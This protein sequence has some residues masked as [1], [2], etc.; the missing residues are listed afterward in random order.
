MRIAVL[1]SSRADYGIYQP[2]LMKMNT[3]A[4]F[5]LEIIAFGMHLQQ[6]QGNTIEFIRK[7][8]YSKIHMVG[9]MPE[10]D[11]VFDIACGY[12]VLVSEFAQ[13]WEGNTFDLV[14]ALGDRWEMSAAVQ[15]CIPFEIK[16]AHFHGGETTL[17]A[18][19]NIYRHQISLAAH[20][21][22]TSE[23]S[24]SERVRLLVNRDVGIHTV[25][26]ISLEHVHQLILPEWSEVKENFNIPF[27]RFVLVTLH[28]ETVKSSGNAEYVRVAFEVLK[29]L[30]NKLNILITMANSDA[31]GSLYNNEFKKL[32]ERYP[33]R[34]RLVPALGRKNYFRAMK[35]CAFLLGNTS[36]GIVE[37]ASF[38]KWV[39]NV[40]N[41]QKGRLRNKNVLDVPFETH[42]ILAKASEVMKRAEYDGGNRYVKRGTIDAII[43][44]ITKDARL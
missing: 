43:G 39:I 6:N 8:G 25:G 44:I 2:L 26:S 4:R 17:G 32:Q 24:F 23:E 14:F 27:D 3:D 20:Y 11:E 19:D 21:H 36:S 29:E 37:A 9:A 42:Q 13:F 1:T 30:S 15:A 12:G 38:K 41:R 18:I 16:I 5:D 10:S 28:P 33:T 40:G 35:Q 34:V 22:F 31:E 7:D